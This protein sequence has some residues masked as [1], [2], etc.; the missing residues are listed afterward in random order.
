[1]LSPELQ[2]ANSLLKRGLRYPIP[3]PLFFRLL[4]KKKFS[5]DIT[6]LCAGTEL[7]ICAILAEKGITEEKVNKAEPAQLMVEHY[8]DIVKIV[9]LASLNEFAISRL[10]MWWRTKLLKGISVWRLWELY[11]SVRQYSG[12]GPFINITRLA[13]EVRMTKPNLGQK[14][15]S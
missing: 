6:Q 15:G 2:A 1:M 8:N 10:A 14:K 3:A 5:I 13:L 9:A 12:T 7:R 11:T 4:G